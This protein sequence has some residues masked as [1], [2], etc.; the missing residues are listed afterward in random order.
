MGF[1]NG[2]VI[3]CGVVSGTIAPLYL[4]NGANLSEP[5]KLCQAK[6]NQ[7]ETDA[8]ERYRP[9]LIVWGSTDEHS[10]IVNDTPA[11]SKVLESGS[12]EWK[13]V[14][15]QRMD[16][17]VKKFLATGAKVVLLLEPATVHGGSPTQPD[18]GDLA[19]ER[20][21]ALLT[22]VAARHP[23]QVAVVN[24]AAR[25]CPSGSTLSIRGRRIRLDR[26]VRGQRNLTGDPS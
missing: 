13:S 18:A 19:F 7:A 10:S 16:D 24:L 3:G 6:A 1:K 12:E 14:M 4:P 15:L 20:M 25:V 5:T 2:A 11:G 23:K 21:N 9:S 17:R 22:Q 8:I 26:N